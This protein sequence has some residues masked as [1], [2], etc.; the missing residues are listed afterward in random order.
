M[1]DWKLFHLRQNWS[2]VMAKTFHSVARQLKDNVMLE[3]NDDVDSV[4]GVCPTV[5]LSPVDQLMIYC[6]P[7]RE[8][9]P[10]PGGCEVVRGC[11]R[12]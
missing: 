10:L 11:M 8:V 1:L 6:R 12:R 4:V 5:D 3:V 9:G 7:H 2:L